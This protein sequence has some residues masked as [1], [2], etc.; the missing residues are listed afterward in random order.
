MSKKTTCVV[1]Q[2][3]KST[4]TVDQ[5]FTK[6]MKYKNIKHRYEIKK[7]NVKSNLT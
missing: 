6:D 7:E 3:S 1:I 5:Y 2:N 4:T